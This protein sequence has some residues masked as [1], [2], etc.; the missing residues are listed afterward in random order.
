MTVKEKFIDFKN[1]LLTKDTLDDK[2]ITLLN[3][4]ENE[5]DLFD[6][7]FTK[8]VDVYEDIFNS[9]SYD[10]YF[11]WNKNYFFNNSLNYFPNNSLL[12]KDEW[13]Y[14]KS[15]TQKGKK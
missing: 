4:V 3:E 10:D 7:I 9:D 2:T 1:D 5:L 15:K 13:N 6:K 12:S 11:Q 8:R 14:L